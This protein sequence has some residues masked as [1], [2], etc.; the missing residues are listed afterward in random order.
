ME[1]SVQVKVNAL[2]SNKKD[3]WRSLVA[4]WI[5]GLC[6]NYGYVVMLS[7]ANDI[8]HQQTER[9]STSTLNGG[10]TDRDCNYISTG[11]ILLADILPSLLIKIIAPF[12]PFFIHIRVLICVMVASMGF[13]LV[14]FSETQWM[15]ITGVV[16]TA[17]C[18]GLGEA[19]LLQYSSFYDK[20]VISTW[21][22]GTGG[23]GIAGALS[24]A[25]LNALGIR[26][27]LLI[28]LVVPVTMAISFWIILPRPQ[29]IAVGDT[30]TL[31]ELPFKEK[32]RILPSLF[33]FMIPIGL[34]YLFE[35][36]INQGMYELINFEGIF[37]NKAE[38]Y[39]WLQVDYQIGVFIS[40]SS[41]N[42]FH[43]RK[44][45]LMSVFQL[46]NVAFFT[47]EAIFYY[48]P[49]F[50]IVL[51]LTFWEGLLGG[52]AYV[53]TFY[54]ISNETPEEHKQFSLGATSFADAV[55]ITLAGIIAISAHNSICSLPK[56]QRLST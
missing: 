50:W 30:N 5:L 41:V 7:A 46:I 19:S 24:Y 13:I 14:A 15:S 29:V 11:A 47:T 36:F 23:A 27:T 45:W 26:T 52:A 32:V 54:K 55:G 39:R 22:S 31:Q 48:I 18:S 53:N 49:S 16:F 3:Y 43:I 4:Y 35:Y 21:S 40:R 10:N 42:I 6:N 34:V 38:Q 37:L 1:P 56:P 28:M 2:Q 12:L 8:L 17:L 20:D 51:A 9:N 33:K 25:T 44:I